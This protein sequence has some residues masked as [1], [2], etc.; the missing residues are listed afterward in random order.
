MPQRFSRALDEATRLL[1]PKAQRVVLPG[2][3]IHNPT[4]LDQWLAEARKQVEEKLKDGP[5]TL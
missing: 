4:E 5:V 2:A 1:E 3:T